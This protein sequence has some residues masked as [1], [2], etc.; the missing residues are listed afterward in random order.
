MPAD[1]AKAA[2]LL[3]FVVVV[4]LSVMANIEI[5]GGHPNLLLVTLVS[6]SLLRGAIFGAVAGFGVGLLADAGVF[7]TL[8][9]TALLLTLAGYWTGRYGET[10]GRDRAH[11]PV[12][13]IAVITVLYQVSA[14]VLRYLLGEPA[15]A[16]DI[17]AA[18]APT[19]LLNLILTVPVYALT[20]RLLRPRE[21]VTR[22]VRL[23]G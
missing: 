19:V 13:S 16:N 1:S 17:F 15:P 7:G 12:L 23:L 6:V 10:T 5:L 8:G 2:G 9:F 21:W 3:F 14:L 20:R 11:A 22:E 18:L 4:Q